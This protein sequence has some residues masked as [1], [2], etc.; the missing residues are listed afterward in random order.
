MN[1]REIEEKREVRD[2]SEYACLSSKSGG[3]ERE[4]A[5]CEVRTCFMRDRDRIIHS[6]SFRRLK[7]KT[8]VFISPEGD[9][10][11][12]RLTHTL[13]V[14]G[15]ARTIARALS[16]NEG[17]CEA[18]AMGHDLGHTPFGHSGERELKA[19]TDGVFSHNLQ[20]ARVVE[21]IEHDGRGLN[22]TRE[23]RDGIACHSGDKVASTLEGRVVALA[24]R[25]AYI[26]HDIDDACR[27][28][29]MSEADI[30]K[31]YRDILGERPSKRINTLVI[32]T[33]KES[34]G[35]DEIKMSDEVNRAMLGLREFMFERVYRAEFALLQEA[36]IRDMIRR[37]FDYYSKD[38][39]YLPEEYRKIAEEDGMTVAVCD[40]IACMTDRYALNTYNELFLP[41]SWGHA[42]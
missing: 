9:H 17:L 26:N 10:Y 4:E 6:K 8:Q 29:L 37:L 36:K 23:V 14:S 18:I 41:I 15:I 31:E 5:E 34:S 38:I 2:L 25:I 1:I 13:E 16:L 3:R 19:L 22:L 35:C 11:R 27:A 32:D 39:S 21:K 42:Q 20:S 30:P 24:D 40:F 33:I 12:T 28:G 7:H